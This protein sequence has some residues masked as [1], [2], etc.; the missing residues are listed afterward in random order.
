VS[1][2]ELGRKERSVLVVY[3]KV[4]LATL[5]ED[6]S[7][8]QFCGYRGLS[9]TD[10]L[11]CQNLTHLQVCGVYHS[12][13]S[14]DRSDTISDF[15]ALKS[16]PNLHYLSIHDCRFMDDKQLA[17]VAS[18]HQLKALSITSFMPTISDHSILGGLRRLTALQLT[19]AT[20]VA[21]VLQLQSLQHVSL[22]D[23]WAGKPLINLDSL[24]RLPALKSAQVQSMYLRKFKVRLNCDVTFLK[25]QS[26]GETQSDW[27]ERVGV[28][29]A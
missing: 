22:S 16:L 6:T 17:Y 24:T 11:G 21:F 7:D 20:D 25:G 15:S 26:G 1:I 28:K 12:G 4:H 8:V 5:R 29:A 14:A 27:W 9:L 13:S 23:K 2:N 19:C 3:S 10:L 18:L